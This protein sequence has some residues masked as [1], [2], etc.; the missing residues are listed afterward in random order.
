M[1]PP[2]AGPAEKAAGAGP[3]SERA[4]LPLCPDGAAALLEAHCRA[5]G[6]E[7]AALLAVGRDG[8]VRIVAVSPPPGPDAEPPGWL[9]EALRAAPQAADDAQPTT[10]PLHEAG[11]LYGQPAAAHL[12]MLPVG[13]GGPRRGVLVLAK[14]TADA[15]GLAEDAGRLEA[16]VSARDL[17]GL[18]LA[19]GSGPRVQPQLAA[20]MAAL[21]AVNEPDRFLAAAMALCNEVAARWQC[22]RV[23]A[24]FLVGGEV[25]LK[26]LSHTEKFSRKTQ[27]VQLLE[28]AMAECLDQDVEVSWP[29]GAEAEYVHRAARELSCAEGRSA[30]ATLP[31][32]RGGG[33]VAALTVERAGERPFTPEEI[34]SLR[35]ACELVTPRLVDLRRRDRWLGAKAAEGLRRA[36]AGVVGPRHTWLKL[37]GV[38]L[39]GLGLYAALAGGEYTVRARFVLQPV[40]RQVAPAP[41]AGELEEVLVEIGQAVRPGEPLARLRTLPLERKLNALRAELFEQQKQAD[42]ARSAKR[43]A[44]AQMAVAR[45]AQL[46]EQIDLLAEQI[47]QATL[48]AR[49]AGTVIEG[50]L[51]GLVGAAVEKG[52]TLFEIAPLDTLRAE[53]SVPEDQVPDVLAAMEAGPVRGE[54][55]AASFPGRKV[56]FVVERVLP[57][58]MDDQEQVAFKARARLAATEP[59][60]RPGMEGVARIGLGRRRVGW[61]WARGLVNRLRLWLWV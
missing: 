7:G 35:L 58:G 49:L 25:E 15:A 9:V 32:R 52:Q 42:A 2:Q 53:L 13:D 18:C 34:E 4:A 59:W 17:Y 41:F 40:R 14:R 22:D 33:P 28:A 21:A 61:I 10:R 5:I 38:L 31:L 6:A 29:A 51:R 44:E 12:A 36:A 11:Q 50:D 37:L 19:A 54:L 24:G 43:W 39:A 16:N 23:G 1:T 20:A 56:P 57:A 45:A 3:P 26:A 60:M 47:D 46:T 8:A 27:T 30:V 55:A 48:R